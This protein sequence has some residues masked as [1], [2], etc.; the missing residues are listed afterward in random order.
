MRYKKLGKT[1]L[2]V[3]EL[4]LGCE[5]LDNK[6]FETAK[7]VIDTALDSG[8]N[9]F[10]VFMPGKEVVILGS[11]DI[12]MIMARR[13]TYEGAQVERVL[14][15]GGADNHRIGFLRPKFFGIARR[16]DISSGLLLVPCLSF[17][18]TTVPDIA[19]GKELKIHI[20]G[21]FQK[22]FSERIAETV[23]KSQNTHSHFVVGADNVG[24]TFC[25]HV[26]GA[27]QRYSGYAE[28]RFFYK[29]AS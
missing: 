12:G 6:P 14:E 9:I 2:E 23:G 21:I 25:R 19:N 10:D 29:F 22:R 28:R 3:S 16:A 5:H 15:I 1:G 20:V 18:A 7:E 13:L 27:S 11:G 4:G 8:V 24:I 17:I 26:H